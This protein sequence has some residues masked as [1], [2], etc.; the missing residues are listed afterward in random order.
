MLSMWCPLQR[1]RAHGCKKRSPWLRQMPGSRGKPLASQMTSIHTDIAETLRQEIE[2]EV[3]FDPYSRALYSTDASIYQIDPIGIVIP[4]H[5]QDVL[6]AVRLAVQH[7]LP[8]LPRGGGTSLSGQTVGHAIH[9]DFSKYMNNVLELNCEERWV[10]IQP[11]VVQDELNAYLHPYGFLLGPDTASSSRATLGGMIGNNSAGAHSILYGKTI[12]HILELTVVLSDGDEALLH[13]VNPE[14]LGRQSSGN[15]LENRIC[16]QIQ[17][18]A[19]EHGDEI[20]R[21]YPKLLRRVSGYNLDEF[22]K[23][24]P[25][26]LAR[27]VVGS[28]GT[29]AVVTEAKVRIVDRPKFTAVEVVHFRS[30]VEAVESSQEILSLQPA[31]MEL[32]DRMILELGRQSL[33]YSRRMNFIQGDPGALMLVEFYGNSR[34][35][36]EAK[37]DALEGKLCEKRMGYATTRALESA[38]QLNIWKVRKGSQ[39]LLMSVLG[40]KKPIAFVEDPAVPVENLPEFLRRFQKLLAGYETTG[41]YYGHASVGCVHI[42]PLI[43]LK[44]SSEIEKMRRISE[45]VCSLV[46]EFGGSMSGEHGDGLARSHHNERLFGPILYEAFRKI[47]TAFDPKNLFN[48]GKV[49]NAPSMTENLRYGS[50][51]QTTEVQTHYDFSSQGG[52]ARAVEMCSGIG[53]CRKTLEG[54]MCPSYM[55]T[56]D[57]EHSTR[58]RANALRAVLSGALP[59]EGFTSRRM[60]DVLDLCIEC[61]GCKRECPSNVDM[62]KIKYEFLAHYQEKHGVPLRSR[63]FG[64]VETLNRWGSRLAPLSNW[65]MRDWLTRQLL[66]SV[67]G[68]TPERR[69]PPFA[70]VNFLDWFQKHRLER[71]G[72]DRSVVL[73][74]DCFMTY[75]YPQIGWAAT[76]L[77]ERLGFEVLLVPKSCCGRPMISK[78]LVA[79]ARS[80]ANTNVEV[81]KPYVDRGIPVVGCEPSCLLTLRD[82]YL[83]LLQGEAVRQLA[84]NSFLIEE[85]LDHLQASTDLS[86]KPA[87]TGRRIFLH[88]HCH[89]KAHIGTGALNRCLQKLGGFE[90]VETDSGCCGMAGSF[91]F[92]AEHYR[93]SMEIGQ[94]HLFKAIRS[95]RADVEVAA[96]G[97]SCRQQ[98]EHGTGRKV[99][100]PVELL[101]EVLH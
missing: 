59:R 92:E 49:V 81:L 69:L 96:S 10:R 53:V 47:K 9:L 13:P 16:R 99:R 55:A 88:G 68:I 43:N 75:N 76:E 46:L 25:F 60:Y 27:M 57:E 91:G 72:R 56:R 100:H 24:Q 19:A 78:G 35:E 7:A 89:Q 95:E 15:G 73:F 85:F 101:S 44:K 33:E 58:G 70:R 11:G 17:T 90:V 22:V 65:V 42:R 28:E 84:R 63:I 12:D 29:L 82:E 80:C 36:V 34:S 71:A 6:S 83:D 23:D 45:E 20:L 14:M 31:A 30:L 52:F 51:Y 40:D 87:A 3:R 1:R 50:S 32:L 86:L 93:L 38:E 4:K 8:I 26:N 2:G 54:T 39:G 5:K 66:R 62:A 97:I 67:T 94:R 61:K 37:I 77:L 18:L 98:I 64:H 79:E 48:P 21:R 74:N 41:G